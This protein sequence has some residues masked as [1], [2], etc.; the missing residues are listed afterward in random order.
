MQTEYRLVAWSVEVKT[1]GVRWVDD[2]TTK[3]GSRLDDQ[4]RGLNFS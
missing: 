2:D 1:W 3:M 4:L